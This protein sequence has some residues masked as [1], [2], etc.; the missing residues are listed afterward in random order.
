MRQKVKILPYFFSRKHASLTVMKN[1][2]IRVDHEF[3]KRVKVAAANRGESIQA[4][5][6]R[7]LST[8]LKQPRELPPQSRQR[9]LHA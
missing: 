4:L 6:T 2:F 9:G 5:V 1:L 7:L 8:E 3:H